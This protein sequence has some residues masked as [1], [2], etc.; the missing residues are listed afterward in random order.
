MS[1]NRI[2]TS[3][4]SQPKISHTKLSPEVT[5]LLKIKSSE[6]K[7]SENSESEMSCSDSE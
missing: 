6:V 1:S 3:L 2:I 5:N 4:R 7:D